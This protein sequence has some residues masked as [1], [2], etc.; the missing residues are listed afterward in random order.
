MYNYSF[1]SVTAL[2]CY[3]ILFVAFMAAQKTK[4]IHSFLVV[5]AAFL[6][7]TGGSLA[8]RMELWPGVEFWFHFS[9]VG[10]II[11]PFTFF[12][13]IYALVDSDDTILWWSWLILAVI[14]NAANIKW[15]FYIPCPEVIRLANGSAGFVYH[16][17]WPIIILFI[18]M[19]FPIIHMFYLVHKS[20]RKNTVERNQLKPIFAGIVILFIGHAGTLVP[21]FRGFPTDVLS[22]IINAGFMFYA[23]YK[24]H[25]FRLT[26]LVSRGVVYG[27][28][29]LLVA[30]LFANYINPLQE[31]IQRNMPVFA[32]SSL[33]IVAVCFALVTFLL[34]SVVKTFIDILFTKGELVQTENLKK[35]ST[36]VSKSLEVADIV[37]EISTVI[38]ETLAVETIYICLADQA[39][40]NYET[41]HR[42]RPISGVNITIRG[43]NPMVEWMRQNRRCIQISEFRRTVLFKSMWEEE[44]QL[45]RELGIQCML[46]LQDEE[47]LA[48]IV[49]LASKKKGKSYGYDDLNFLESVSSIASIAVRNSRLYEKA[50]MEA[51]TDELTGLLNRK[52]FYELLNQQYEKKP[53]KELALIIINID[54]FKLYNQLYG[55]KEGDA[56]LQ[57]AAKII[58]ATVG[59]RGYV[60]RYSGKE[61]AAALPEFDVL[62]ARNIAESIRMQILNMNK[63][64]T[65]YALKVLTVSCGICTIPYSAS[66]IKQLVENADMA[67]F[68]VKRKGK[69]GVMVYDIGSHIE[70][71]AKGGEPL[72]REEVYTSYQSTIYALTAAIDA[73]DHYTFS[74]SRHVAEYA[75]ILAEEYGMSEDFIELVREAGLLHDIGKIG[76]PEHILNK[77]GRLEPEEYETMK[78]HVEAAIG[79]IRN[80][81]SLD[82]VIP[83]VIGHHE[84]YDGKGYPRGIAGEDI[85]LSARIL[86]I[87]D[88]FDAMVSKRSYKD[89]CSL[90]FAMEEIL[91][92]AGRQFDPQ[93]APLFVEAVRKGKI[94][95]EEE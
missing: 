92:Q 91:K 21:V 45:I 23:L 42:S 39:G 5:L 29:T 82:Y 15:G 83:A 80:L 55:M 2:F 10:L 7:W 76:I 87:A 31:F 54:D 95:P 4:I 48:G 33:L 85:P 67:V 51:R 94:K 3:M 6:L 25:L 63:R 18:T 77:P 81:P 58:S 8:M 27:I 26:L 74:H 17:G 28:S 34:S 37:E 19:S 59:E 65:D 52:Y 24:K 11:L 35:F 22:G 72:V 64:A 56:A 88:S 9:I 71:N 30:L 93:L 36:A 43:D 14:N 40:E 1:I 32:G 20:Y 50:C 89:R 44:K 57:N 70:G 46:P 60:A 66:N 68:S 62:A 78:G 53:N 47:S 69:N 79:I 16:I 41:A 90:E 75:G 49:L 84:R 73:K 86:C 13:F 12:N 38:Q 61:F